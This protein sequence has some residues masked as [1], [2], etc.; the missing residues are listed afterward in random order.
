MTL[1][2][3]LVRLTLT[4][5]LLMCGF[6]TH[7]EEDGAAVIID[8]EDIENRIK[9]PDSMDQDVVVVRCGAGLDHR[10]STAPYHCFRTRGMDR[11]PYVLAINNAMRLLPFSPAVVAGKPV[12]VWF[13]FSVVFN[14]AAASVSVFDSLLYDAPNEIT[15]YYVAPQ[16]LLTVHSP[17][18]CRK[19][20]AWP[21]MGVDV[22]GKPVQTEID[23]QNGSLC[24]RRSRQILADSSYIP[25]TVN[26]TRVPAQYREPF[27]AGLRKR[28]DIENSNV[29]S[30]LVQ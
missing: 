23:K 27:S 9:V 30:R 14:K 8:V 11:D 3:F 24:E 19:K 10:Y 20:V 12:D 25:A 13:N 26:G 2:I 7:A 21:T 28:H 16:R 4:I 18:S 15:S 22:K 5:T 1:S 29:G 17:R 6:H